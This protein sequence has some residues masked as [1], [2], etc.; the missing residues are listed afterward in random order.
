[1][2]LAGMLEQSASRTPDATALWTS[3]GR[4]SYAELAERVVRCARGLTSLRL[5]GQDRVAMLLPNDSNLVVSI[6]AAARAGLVAVPLSP[7]FAP[8]QL[9]YI[10]AHSGTR[11]LVTTPAL[12]ER[13]TTEARRALDAIVLCGRPETPPAPGA[14]SF[15]QL[16]DGAAAPPA[17]SRGAVAD[18]IG[19]LVYTSGTTSRPKGVA[20]TQGRMAHRVRLLVDE[21]AL[22]ADDATV[23]YMNVGRPLPLLSQL[24]PM[25]CVGGAV[26]LVERADP[27]LF[28]QAFTAVRPTYEMTPPGMTRDLLE[29]PAARDADTDRL[30]FWI[31][32]GDV[33]PPA[34][35]ALMSDIVGKPVLEMCGM[36]ETGFY[37]ISPRHGPRKP[38]SIGQAMMGV[39]VR[40]VNEHGA[41][42]AVGEVGR[43][44][45]RTPDMMVGYW[46]DTLA[47]HRL[48]SSGWLDTEDLARADEDGFLWFTGR[49]KDMISRGGLKV[50]PAMVEAALLTHPAVANAA[51]VGAADDREGQ[52]PVA[53]YELRPGAGD[54][55]RDSLVGWLSARVEPLSVPVE[56]HRVERWPR[57]AQGKLDRSRLTWM[58]DFGGG[59]EL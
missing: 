22:A 17:V 24:M 37:C 58:A 29:H 14:V 3:A 54:P 38:G 27:S 31:V 59:Q 35:H 30:R 46:N 16:L 11:V 8:P 21:L 13:V 4:L 32:G 1:M 56:C 15:T 48:L 25:L 9:E 42:A 5:S 44:H 55:G 28:W 6:L 26:G 57:T 45:V 43:I 12:L 33:C 23:A 10:L 41:D 51:V 50:A 39:A 52:V 40:I 19:L 18:P 2:S 47:T 36:T 34:V 49:Q 7:T 53:F 20:H